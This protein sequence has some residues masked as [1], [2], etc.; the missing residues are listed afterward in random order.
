MKRAWAGILALSVLAFLAL[1]AGMHAFRIWPR[2]T[3]DVVALARFCVGVA[4]FAGGLHAFA[5]WLHRHCRAVARE[6]RE[7]RLGW[8]LATTGILFALFVAGI[9]AIGLVHET[10]WYVRR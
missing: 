6:G 5:V 7:W 3:F 1:E 10:T 9:C 2:V 4:L 8:S